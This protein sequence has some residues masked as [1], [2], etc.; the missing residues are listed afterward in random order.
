MKD[1]YKI[2]E[3][4]KGSSKDEVKKAFRRL[5]AKYH[6]DKKGG[7]EAKFKELSEAYSVLSDD[8]KRAEY[9]TYGRSYAGGAQGAGGFNWGGAQGAE[10]DINDIFEN[11]GDMFGGG[12]GG[13]RAQQARGNDISID[14]QLSFKEAVF[15][16]KRTVT[17]TKN[18]VCETCDGTGAKKGSEMTTCSTC[19]GNGK[20]RETRQSILG[21]FTTVR[22]CSTCNGKGKVPKE[23]CS[24]CNGHGIKRSSEQIEISIPAGIE[25]GEMIRMTGRGEAISNGTPGDLYIKIHVERHATIA[26]EGTQLMSILNIKLSDALLGGSYQVETLDGNVTLKIPEGIKHGEMLRIKNKGVPGAG[27]KRGDF[28]VKIAI[29]I[30]QKLSKQAKKLIEQLKEEGI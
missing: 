18:N 14:I 9:D 28:I 15:G 3:V 10:F 13:G 12:F 24:E 16:T 22:E 19:N 30:P 26:R 17:L 7:D 29:D 11:F 23:P 6:P 20:I 27:S 1:Y 25:N 5:A 2:L 21:A 4:E 8:K